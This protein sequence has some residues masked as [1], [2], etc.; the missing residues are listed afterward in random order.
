MSSQTSR[1]AKGLAIAAV[2]AVVTPAAGAGLVTAAAQGTLLVA[3]AATVPSLRASYAAPSGNEDGG[4]PAR[5]S[6]LAG[7]DEA[8]WANARS[9]GPIVR[10]LRKVR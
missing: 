6:P 7:S 5:L 10:P 3:D 4:G 1:L 8:A 2:F 9:V